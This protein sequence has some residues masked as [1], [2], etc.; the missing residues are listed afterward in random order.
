MIYAYVFNKK[1]RVSLPK[2]Q[3]GESSALSYFR[4]Y[5]FFPYT[6]ILLTFLHGKIALSG[7]GPPHYRDTIILRHTTLGRTPLDK[8]SARSREVYL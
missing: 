1:H 5:V 8:W 4:Q 2:K 3:K 7:T 6:K